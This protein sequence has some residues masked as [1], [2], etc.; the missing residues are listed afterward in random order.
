MA[1]RSETIYLILMSAMILGVFWN[2]YSV[3]SKMKK[4]IKELREE[5]NK[6]KQKEKNN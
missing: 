3:Y 5:V 1:A 2:I 6:L 4:E